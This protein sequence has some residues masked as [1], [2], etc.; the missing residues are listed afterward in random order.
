MGRLQNVGVSQ[1]TC[2]YLF[3]SFGPSEERIGMKIIWIG[4]GVR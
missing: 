4:D 3:I 2:Q 1:K